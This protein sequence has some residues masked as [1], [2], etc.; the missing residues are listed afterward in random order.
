[1]IIVTGAAGQLGRIVIA[2]LYSI[3]PAHPEREAVEGF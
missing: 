3:L 1:M 2:K